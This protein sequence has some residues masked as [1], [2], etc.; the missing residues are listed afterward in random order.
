MLNL[1]RFQNN[2]KVTIQGGYK[3][4]HE[5]STEE[6]E[7]DYISTIGM[8]YYNGSFDI[9]ITNIGSVGKKILEHINKCNY[10]D[11]KESDLTIIDNRITWNQIEDNDCNILET[12][13]E[14]EESDKCYICDYDIFVSINGIDLTEEELR[15]IL[16]EAE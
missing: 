13:E 8:E 3:M 5:W 9:D 4:V 12:I 16:P 15:E 11:F 7:G 10:T 1:Q 6:G 14:E 2:F